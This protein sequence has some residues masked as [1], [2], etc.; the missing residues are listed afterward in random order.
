MIVKFR[1]IVFVVVSDPRSNVHERGAFRSGDPGVVDETI[2]DITTTTSCCILN[3]ANSLQ[4]FFSNFSA[5]FFISSDVV[6]DASAE[7]KLLG[8]GSVVDPFER[9]G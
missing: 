5:G 6:T 3:T 9:V 2:I 7:M 8:D 4:V 1:E